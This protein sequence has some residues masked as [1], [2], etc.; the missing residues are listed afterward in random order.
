MSKPV[1]TRERL[2]DATERIIRE[3]GIMA[4]TTKDIAREAGYAEATLYR[5]FADKAELLLA[6]MNER[7]SGHFLRLIGELP[8]RA[9]AGTVMATLEE[10]AASAVEFFAHVMPLNVALAS[11]PVLAA[12]HNA[13]LR[14]LGTGPEA[15]LRSVAAYLDAEQRQGRVRADANPAAV[16][17]LLLGVCFNYTQVRHVS[18]EASTILPKDQFASEIARTL[19]DGLAPTTAIEQSG[20]KLPKANTPGDPQ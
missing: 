17:T 15:A 1:S 8:A 10:V 7:L 19:I 14:S 20:P 4:V 5:H 6:V 12:A 18:G 9:G 16:A 13:R 11:D 2:M 3:Q